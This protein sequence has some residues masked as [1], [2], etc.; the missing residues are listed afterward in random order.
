MPVQLLELI[1]PKRTVEPHVG[2]L[3][4]D[5]VCAEAFVQVFEVDEIEMLILVKA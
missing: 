5:A 3:L 2:E 1:S 4:L